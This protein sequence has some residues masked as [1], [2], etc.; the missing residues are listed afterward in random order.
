MEPEPEKGQAAPSQ[1]KQRS[2]SATSQVVRTK[3]KQPTE[4]PR[5]SQWSDSHT[6]GRAQAWQQLPKTRKRETPRVPKPQSSEPGGRDTTAG[7]GGRGGDAATVNQRPPR[8]SLRGWPACQEQGH[9]RSAV[10]NV[11]DAKESTSTQGTRGPSKRHGRPGE[12][13]A[14]DGDRGPPTERPP[15]PAS[16]LAEVG[17]RGPDWPSRALGRR[18][19][20]NRRCL[21]PH[22][23]ERGFTHTLGGRHPLS[24]GVLGHVELTSDRV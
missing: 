1:N 5:G 13:N 14:A 18:R 24:S 22:L 23:R 8:P 9:N 16:E 10:N 21:L 6:G 15:V 11:T 2:P 17:A 3:R 12:P 19:S 4:V 20:R 7:S